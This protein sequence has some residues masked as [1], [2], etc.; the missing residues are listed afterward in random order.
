MPTS[1]GSRDY[2]RFDQLADEFAERYRRGERPNLQDYIDRLPEM[3]DEIREM[4]PA[5]VEV[6]Q[7]KGDAR[8]ETPP[9]PSLA[10]PRLRELGD[11]RIVR[12]VGRGGMGVVYEAEQISLGRRVA[13]KVLP[14]QVVADRKA[15][16]RF[17]REA[18]AAARLHHTNIVPVFEVGRDGETAFYAMQFI[19][20]QGLDRVIDELGRLRNGD[21]KSA[22]NDR[23]ASARSASV[24]AADLQ[25]WK[26]ERVAESL[27]SGRLGITSVWPRPKTMV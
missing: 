16:E 12:E 17:R 9:Q 22:G 2:D 15:L 19:Q 13:L 23:A 21:A 11:Y 18:K 24:T 14:G 3:A 26:L 27:L 25:N 10:T 4:F 6:E 1:A 5:L 7:A 20:G 8:D